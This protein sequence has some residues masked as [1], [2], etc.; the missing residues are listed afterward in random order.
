MASATV[1]ITDARIIQACNTPGGPVYEWRNKKEA[2][3]LRVA[4]NLSP[5]NDPQ[6][7][8]H[9]GGN[10]GTFRRSFVSR[11]TGNQHH[12]GFVVENF[13]DHAIYVELGR[14]ASSKRQVFSWTAWGGDIRAVPA[15][16]RREGQH[17]LRRAVN[18]AS[19]GDW[20]PVG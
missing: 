17:V 16:R 10:V 13:A 3:V 8:Q 12:V 14:S 20:G 19:G 4:Y 15:T 6:N 2:E 7:A 9:R 18:A 1:H 11:R 5:V